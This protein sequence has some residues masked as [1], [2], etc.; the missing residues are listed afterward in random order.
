MSF[1]EPRRGDLAPDDKRAESSKV[2][3]TKKKLPLDYMEND[4]RPV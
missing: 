3:S 1:G 2:A 4:I